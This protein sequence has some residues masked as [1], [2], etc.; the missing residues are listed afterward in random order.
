MDLMDQDKPVGPTFLAY[1]RDRKPESATRFHRRRSGLPRRPGQPL[2][3]PEAQLSADQIRAWLRELWAIDS[4]PLPRRG[5]VSSDPLGPTL[6]TG[7]N[8]N[9]CR[10]RHCSRRSRRILHPADAQPRIFPLLQQASSDDV[11]ALLA[12]RLHLARGE[13]DEAHALVDA[14]L[15][16]LRQGKGLSYTYQAPHLKPRARTANPMAKRPSALPRITRLRTP[17]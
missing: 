16:E 2:A 8:A 14:M 5:L 6:A 7:C 13:T 1:L 11:N 12:V 3:P 4:A 10:A 17:W 15:A 9:R